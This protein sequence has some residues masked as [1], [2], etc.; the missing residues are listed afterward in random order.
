MDDRVFKLY[1]CCIAVRG[2]RRSTIC[3]LQRPRYQLVPNGL[4]EILTTHR[5]RSL[6]QIKDAY[7]PEQE[8][9][10]DEYFAFLERN[11][12]GF[13]CDDPDAFPDLNLHW[14]TPERI[15]NAIIDVGPASRHD[16]AS[17]IRQLDELGCR[18]L[19]LRFFVEI[20]LNEL[21][22]VLA[23]AATSGLRSIE[24]V[25]KYRAEWTPE[26]LEQLIGTH[27]RVSAVLLHSAPERKLTR[28]L[29]DTTAV[30]Y[31][32]GVVHSESHCGQVD[33]SQFVPTLASFAEATT[34]NS[35]L[36]KKIGIDQHGEI[37]SCPSM[38]RSF[39]NAA[40]TSLHSAVL[41]RDFREL[42]QVNKDQIDVCRDC[43]FRYVCTDCRAYIQQPS[44]P[45]S[46]PSKCG[47]DP[48]TAEWAVPA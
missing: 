26:A 11:E 7:G 47:Y 28:V 31:D 2:A 18:A 4:Y 3:D 37:R 20:S 48:Y 8:E 43:E 41:Q 21:D 24:I 32:P 46:K 35:C 17:L 40:T 14:E 13:W 15:S 33:P 12:Y 39:G 16:F 22:H 30:F 29:R 9:T 19:Q 44:D 23:M 36:N 42:W 1:A 5:G 6:Q 38:P 45:F 34:R 25:A 27:A 10:I